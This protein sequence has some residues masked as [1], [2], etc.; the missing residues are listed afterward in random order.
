MSLLADLWRLERGLVEAPCPGCGG[1]R[2]QPI[3]LRDRYLLRVEV[4]LCL[5]CGLVHTARGL[6]PGRAEEFYRGLYPRLMRPG[7]EGPRLATARRHA[8]I[9]VQA[10]AAAAPRAAA[11]VEIG[12]GLGCFLE[13]CRAHGIPRLFGLEPSPQAR[14]HAAEVL[15]LAGL[16]SGETV[17][18]L[19]ALPF[20]PDTVALFH[21][22]EHLDDPGALLDRIR[23]WLPPAGW[24]VLEVPDL[25]GPWERLG[26]QNFHVSHRSYFSAETLCGLLARHGFAARQV[27]RCGDD[28]IYPG[29]LRVLAQ[30]G[31]AEP[32]PPPAAAAVLSHIRQRVS[33]WSPRHG[34]PRGMLRLARLALGV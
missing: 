12:C 27:Q 22:L 7:P 13:A 8:A 33:P 14:R 10:L 11:V 1:W 29:N 30:P 34:H 9:R 26:L 31:A 16:I 23:D 25:L 20:P 19:H 15:G 18:R 4:S 6:A 3:L 5:D 2:R 28:G 32:P 21:V 24:L 17:E